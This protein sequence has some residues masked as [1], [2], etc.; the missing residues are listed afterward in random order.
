MGRDPCA[1]VELKPDAT[2]TEADIV[3][4]CREHLARSRCERVVFGRSRRPPQA[5][6]R[7]SSCASRRNPLPPSSE[8]VS[9]ERSN[10]AEVQAPFVVRSDADGI[11]TLTL[12]R[13]DRLNPLSSAMLGALQSALDEVAG[14]RVSVSSSSRGRQAFLR[15]ARSARMRSR[16]DKAWQSALFEQ[17]G[18]VMMSLVRLPSR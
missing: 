8:G 6:S 12:S 18:R 1:F 14:T 10:A 16:P 7:S 3:A 11:A 13:G 5:R 2:L 4:H 15:R 9:N 17:C